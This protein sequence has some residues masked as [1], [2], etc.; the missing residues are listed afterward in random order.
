MPDLYDLISPGF[1]LTELITLSV[2]LFYSAL[3]VWAY[4]TLVYYPTILA[5]LSHLP[6]RFS[7]PFL[8]DILAHIFYSLDTYCSCPHTSYITQP[9]ALPPPKTKTQPPKWSGL[10]IF[11]YGSIIAYNLWALWASFCFHFLPSQ[12]TTIM[13]PTISTAMVTATPHKNGGINTTFTSLF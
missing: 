2:P 4:M 5:S 6:H 7:V 8:F 12:I 10:S 9:H 1:S 13:M 11:S 3:S